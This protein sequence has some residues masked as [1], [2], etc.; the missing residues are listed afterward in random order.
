MRLRPWSEIQRRGFGSAD[1]SC[2]QGF[3]ITT[4][5]LECT[6]S[7]LH[8]AAS[9]FE[10]S[11]HPGLDGWSNPFPAQMAARSLQPLLRDSKGIQG[12]L[13]WSAAIPF[14]AAVESLRPQDDLPAAVESFRASAVVPTKTCFERLGGRSNPFPLHSHVIPLPSVCYVIVQPS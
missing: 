8:T 7:S 3:W 11:I 12:L 10:R 6:K 14:P 4:H 5:R 13:S 2:S 1:A 9:H